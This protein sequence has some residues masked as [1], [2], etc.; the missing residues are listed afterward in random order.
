MTVYLCSCESRGGITTPPPPPEP[1]PYGEGNGK[2][3]FFRTQQIAGT[4]TIKIS[5]STLIDTIVWQSAPNC[6][7]NIAVYKI[8]KAGNYSVRIEGSTFLCDYNVTVE[9]RKCKLLEYTN[10]GGGNVG[11]YALDGLWL[12]TADGPCPNCGGLKVLFSGGTGEVVYTPP[13]C[14]F[15]LGD[16]KWRDFLLS[17][18]KVLDLARDQYGGS[19]QYFISAITFFNKDSIILNGE[20]GIIPYSRIP[21]TNEKR[22]YKNII[23]DSTA[24]VIKPGLRLEQ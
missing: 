3:T 24:A 15:P 11:C 22:T 17:D 1:N 20:S 14:R 7:S 2:I 10:C 23:F 18:C 9:E 8:L 21:I 16:I 13:G 6:D 12:R 4:V 5:D 19:P